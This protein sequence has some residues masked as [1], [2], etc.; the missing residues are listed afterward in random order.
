[1]LDYSNS[2]DGDAPSERD[3]DERSVPE[4]PHDDTTD[5]GGDPLPSGADSD[6]ETEVLTRHG[7]D[8]VPHIDGYDIKRKL[9]D[10]GM[11]AIYLAQQDQPRRRV[12]IKVIRTVGGEPIRESLL[13]RFRYEAETQAR[14]RHPHIAEVYQAGTFEDLGRTYPYFAME[15]ISGARTL[16]QYAE[17][18]QLSVRRRLELFECLCSAIGLAHQR[19]VIHRDIKPSNVLV[20]VD[21]Q[22]KVIDF[23]VA[24]S[25]DPE[26]ALTSVQTHVARWIGTPRYMSPEQVK[27]DPDCIDVRSDVYS[28]G[29]VLYELLT[30]EGPYDVTNKPPDEISRIIQEQK[31]EPLSKIDRRLGGDLQRIASRALAKD[32]TLRYSNAS[33]LAS[34]I[35]AFLAG[36]SIMPRQ[37][38]LTY[39]L[40]RT[41]ATAIRQHHGIAVILLLVASIL[42]TNY[43]GVA[44]VYRATDLHY[45]F[46]NAVASAAVAGIEDEPIEHTRIIKVTV[47]DWDGALELASALGIADYDPEHPK[48]MRRIFAEAVSAMQGAGADVIAIDYQYVDW[49]FE[50]DHDYLDGIAT[51]ARTARDA[52]IPVLV[53]AGDWHQRS[54]GEIDMLPGLKGSVESGTALVFFGEETVWSLDAHVQFSPNHSDSQ[55]AVKILAARHRPEEAIRQQITTDAE[56]NTLTISYFG[57]SEEGEGE[58]FLPGASREYPVSAV[59]EMRDE[60]DEFEPPRGSIVTHMDFLLHDPALMEDAS[61]TLTEFFAMT[62]AER[63][64]WCGN[65]ITMLIPADGSDEKIHP[66]YGPGVPG[67]FGLASFI[68]R[69]EDGMIIQAESSWDSVLF[70][71][72]PVCILGIVLTTVLRNRPFIVVIACGVIVAILFYLSISLLRSEH[73]WLD[74]VTPVLGLAV[75]VLGTAGF[76]SVRRSVLN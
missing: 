56:S 17:E 23:G 63:T 14:L 16:T 5:P 6:A 15:Y 13:S 71:I 18:H 31:P 74:P 64:A 30:G 58:R 53:T 46:R 12:A 43:I 76:N 59:Y 35:N 28:L 69:A 72:T 65:R 49:G 32:P 70:V 24:R 54:R 34:D 57:Q 29:V 66:R 62:E 36:E 42:F 21:G 25:A 4:S 51:N 67:G 38:N 10:G 11:G 20:D 3:D 68:E 61:V 7:S 73:L 37:L 48:S 45:W 40:Q 41:M 2:A 44:V 75:A 26:G 9:T 52:G 1:M 47:D 60:P 50:E 8:H 19:G 39:L 27:G 55:F 22:V 33:E